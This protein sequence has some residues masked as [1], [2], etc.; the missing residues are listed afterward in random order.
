[1]KKIILSLICSL[2]LSVLVSAQNTAV[3][4]VVPFDKA[5][6]RPGYSVTYKASAKDVNTA[7]KNRMTKEGLKGK[8]F[9]KNVTKYEQVNK[10]YICAQTCDLYLKVEGSG[11]SANLTCFVSKGYDNFVSSANDPETANLAKLFVESFSKDVEAVALL[12]QI[13]AQ[14]KVLKKAEGD[15]KK[16]VKEKEKVQKQLDEADKKVKSLDSEREKQKKLLEEL[17]AK[18]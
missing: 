10:P 2:G 6:T 1:M 9:A 17:K 13:A 3:E 11:S 4:K 8:G 16:G 7:V 14:E 5:N 12:A 18:Q 15:Y